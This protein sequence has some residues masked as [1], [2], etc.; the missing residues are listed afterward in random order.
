MSS[1]MFSKESSMCMSAKRFSRVKQGSASFSHDSNR[2]HLLS[3][4][5]DFACS[6]YSRPE[7]WKKHSA[8]GLRLP[9]IS[10]FPLKRS[11]IRWLKLNKQHDDSVS[12]AHAS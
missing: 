8:A 11:H 1:S 2:M 4:P 7:D 9:N 5:F 12:T 3:V 10:I 6:F